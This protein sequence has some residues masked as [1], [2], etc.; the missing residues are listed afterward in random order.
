KVY[1]DIIEIK[2]QNCEHTKSIDNIIFYGNTLNETSELIETSLQGL[3]IGLEN[4]DGSGVTFNAPND[5]TNFQSNILFYKAYI[6]RIKNDDF[7]GGEF[8]SSLTFVIEYK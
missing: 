8:T 1:S 5:L 7:H 2:F 3:A 4:L 6:E